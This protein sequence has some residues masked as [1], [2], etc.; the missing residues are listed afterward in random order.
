MGNIIT[1]EM[2]AAGALYFKENFWYWC[3]QDSELEEDPRRLAKEVYLLMEAARLSSQ[4]P[5]PAK[6]DTISS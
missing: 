5:K 2:L 3:N 6:D 4:P 1:D